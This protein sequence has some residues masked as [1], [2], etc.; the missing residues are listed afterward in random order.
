MDRSLAYA[1]AHVLCSR[2]AEIAMR[3]GVSM[4]TKLVKV[5]PERNNGRRNL[6]PFVGWGVLSVLGLWGGYARAQATQTHVY[7]L[8]PRPDDSAAVREAGWNLIAF[9]FERSEGVGAVLRARG[10]FMSA[11]GV[12]ADGIA[13]NANV[14]IHRAPTWVYA[15]EETPGRSSGSVWGEWPTSI[16]MDDSSWRVIEV[17]RKMARA[18]LHYKRVLEWFPDDGTYRSLNE[19]D[20]LVPGRGYW[21]EGFLDVTQIE[22]AYARGANTEP[23]T[24]AAAYSANERGNYEKALAAR[25]ALT[26]RTTLGLSEGAPYFYADHNPPLSPNGAYQVEYQAPTGASGPSTSASERDAKHL[27]GFERVWA[28]TLGIALLQAT[29]QQGS[30]GDARAHH[31]WTQDLARYLC[32]HAVVD[33]EDPDKLRGWHF[34]W[35]TDQD[36]WRD[37]RLVT[38]AS[39]WALHGVGSFM[40]SEAF[41]A[42]PSNK[43]KTW[44]KQCYRGALLG[45]QEHRRSVTM[46]GGRTVSF[47]TA[48]WTTEGLKYAAE[49]HRLFRNTQGA[50]VH[51][52]QERWAYY[53]VLDAIG[54][55]TFGVPPQIKVCIQREGGSCASHPSFGEVWVPR[56]I[57]EKTWTALR[58]PSKADNVVTE[59]LLD[60]LSVLNH[61]LRHSEELG[62][63]EEK[64]GLEA[65]RN[66]VRDAVFFALWDQDDAREEIEKALEE[67]DARPEAVRTLDSRKRQ[68]IQ[69]ATKK[70]GDRSFGRVVT[71]GV[72][73]HRGGFQASPH[74]AIDNCSWLALSVNHDELKEK[75]VDSNY[76]MR[77]EQCLRYT[78]I[79]FAKELGYGTPSC[80]SSRDACPGQVRYYGAHYFQNTFEDPYILPSALQESSYHLEATMGLIGGLLEFARAHP[81]RPS[82]KAFRDEALRLWAGAQAFVHDHGFLYSSQRIQDLSAVLESST[83]IIW[84][85]DVYDRLRE[86]DGALDPG[87][88]NDEAGWGAA[89][90]VAGGENFL[91]TALT[92]WVSGSGVM[93]EQARLK[94]SKGTISVGKLVSQGGRRASKLVTELLKLP[95]ELAAASIAAS[96]G[97]AFFASFEYDAGLETLFVGSEEPQSELWSRAGVV[98]PE[99]VLVFSKTY[100]LDEAEIRGR[101]P[102]YA[103]GPFDNPSLDQVISFEDDAIYYIK[104]ETLELHSRE[105]GDYSVLAPQDGSLWEVFS[106][107][108]SHSRHTLVDTFVKHHLLWK[109]AEEI[110]RAVPES[111]REAW[112]EIVALAIRSVFTLDAAETLAK[113]SG[114]GRV[115]SGEVDRDLAAK[116]PV[117]PFFYFE[118]DEIASLESSVDPESIQVQKTLPPEFL[119]EK[120][121]TAKEMWAKAAEFGAPAVWGTTQ[122]PPGQ[123]IVPADEV[124]LLEPQGFEAR[125]ATASD[126]PS[127]GSNLRDAHRLARA[128]RDQRTKGA[129][130]LPV[131]LDKK[132]VR[133]FHRD[134]TLAENT[135]VRVALTKFDRNA[136][137]ESDMPHLAQLELI[138]LQVFLLGTASQHIRFV[139][140]SGL[141]AKAYR[142]RSVRSKERK[143]TATT[144]LKALAPIWPQHQTSVEVANPAFPVYFVD[145]GGAWDAVRTGWS[146]QAPTPKQMW[147]KAKEYNMVVVWGETADPPGHS[148]IPRAELSNADRENFKVK[149][150]TQ[151]VRPGGTAD[152]TV[153]VGAILDHASHLVHLPLLVDDNTI[154]PYDREGHVVAKFGLAARTD[155]IESDELLAN[156]GSRHWIV[157]YEKGS[158]LFFMGSI[159]TIKAQVMAYPGSYQIVAVTSSDGGRT[160]HRTLES[161]RTNWPDAPLAPWVEVANPIFPSYFVDTQGDF[162][163]LR[164]GWLPQAPSRA[165]LLRQAADHGGP[166]VYG[167]SHNPEGHAVVRVRDLQHIDKGQ[168]EPKMATAAGHPGEASLRRVAMTGQEVAKHSAHT[169]ATL[170]ILWNESK[171][172][173]YHRADGRAT[174]I[175]VVVGV[176]PIDAPALFKLFSHEEAAFQIHVPKMGLYLAGQASAIGYALNQ[177]NIGQGEYTVYALT[178]QDPSRTAHRAMKSL[179]ELKPEGQT[180]FLVWHPQ[181]EPYYVDPDG[182]YDPVRTGWMKE[183]PESM[184][185]WQRANGFAGPA[186]LG[187]TKRPQGYSIVPLRD[188]G[189]VDPENFS[190][191]LAT[192]T[193]EESGK[194]NVTHAGKV[195]RTIVAIPSHRVYPVRILVSLDE[196]LDF[197]RKARRLESKNYRPFGVQGEV[198][199]LGAE[200]H[201]KASFREVAKTSDY[202]LMQVRTRARTYYLMPAHLAEFYLNKAFLGAG[203]F[204]EYISQPIES[205]IGAVRKIRSYLSSTQESIEV[206]ISNRDY[207]NYYGLDAKIS[208]PNGKSILRVGRR[209]LDQEGLQA[210]YDT[211]GFQFVQARRQDDNAYYL[212]KRDQAPVLMALH[213]YD[214]VTVT[215]AK[216]S[217]YQRR[218]A[219]PFEGHLPEGEGVKEVVLR[220]R[221]LSAA[222]SEASDAAPKAA[223]LQTEADVIPE[224][225]LPDNEVFRSWSPKP[226]LEPDLARQAEREGISLVQATMASQFGGSFVFPLSAWKQARG[227]LSARFKDVFIAHVNGLGSEIAKAFLAGN[228]KLPYVKTRDRGVTKFWNKDGQEIFPSIDIV[229]E[230][231]QDREWLSDLL[232]RGTEPPEENVV[233]ER[234]KL[235]KSSLVVVHLQRSHHY[236]TVPT[237]QTELWPLIEGKGP[238]SILFAVHGSSDT[239]QAGARLAKELE[240]HFGKK[241]DYIK[242]LGGIQTGQPR[243]PIFANGEG[244]LIYPVMR[245]P[246]S[247]KGPTLWI[248]T[249]MYVGRKEPSDKDIA[250]ASLALNQADMMKVYHPQDDFYSVFPAS[251][252]EGAFSEASGPVEVVYLLTAATATN[253]KK[254]RAL[255]YGP[256]YHN[257]LIIKEYSG[258]ET[259]WDK[260]GQR[261]FP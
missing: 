211:V 246:Q 136:L 182:A 99:D 153:V 127:H 3:F 143:R 236:V 253:Q 145:P 162:D 45:L 158:R 41:R 245:K 222:F 102:I 35:N 170:P 261:I 79:R 70:E 87:L 83:A 202:P 191:E 94:P 43:E 18:Q 113:G 110:T 207:S 24:R 252:S 16:L 85:I 65:W 237:K 62:L 13:P 86:R 84:F 242:V 39:A 238:H 56:T 214:N 230:A 176:R 73:D 7:Q 243:L 60:T 260:Q 180:T 255:Q 100:F 248:T 37:A 185:L 251:L 142:F 124:A 204:V 163:P 210:T 38:G 232:Y 95:P 179:G 189:K 57:D 53:D 249:G 231:V 114:L 126:R 200:G 184:T 34:S 198:I 6:S 52:G 256:Y 157:I 137:I 213:A 15:G 186:V 161:I 135:L 219:Y 220:E 91:E 257:A 111:F 216:N 11:T 209:P 105:F 206:V 44:F 239:E 30:V 140:D 233:Q 72:L 103:A 205:A 155:Y 96:T 254:R 175:E 134:G 178:S 25:A 14:S 195:A 133:L 229:P 131:L 146:P 258:Q 78:V 228:P 12:Q 8:V 225:D 187:A 116:N 82:S 109:S 193:A 166:V 107:D 47:M 32:A 177:G 201:T 190:F 149:L 5:R 165:F 197:D 10:G 17:H 151:G 61:A 19:D 147:A 69:E 144:A 31:I 40:T 141:A 106:L 203:Y 71:G 223:G 196:V 181:K 115:S 224:V 81:K 9:P 21:V 183:R 221:S 164:H 160:A 23:V 76:V 117:A 29:R 46:E 173:L 22:L 169:W 212:I 93:V 49:P 48:G 89:L 167:L 92:E 55:S 154:R 33:S 50:G 240:P 88:K 51:E 4:S 227:L 159:A 122:N 218:A 118:K 152:L 234:A 208:F 120:R 188:L 75:N 215:V 2:I 192:A 104:A 123:A 27:A 42:L 247:G 139:K 132:Q 129:G 108:T 156:K 97:A 125:L 194:D 121:P 66:E 1:I 199:F 150:A 128:L 138:D 36:N 20:I 130:L 250:E 259:V 80:D 119:Q 74:T 244:R 241:Q 54:Y 67:D 112:L 28:Y 168:F 63:L 101:A 59:H 226:E 58:R 90:A 64:S 68:W 217:T 26:R 77:L 235:T 98:V 171:A 174:S 148:V 172:S